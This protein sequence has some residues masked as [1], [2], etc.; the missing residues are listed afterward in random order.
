MIT[1]SIDD[2]KRDL[3]GYLRRVRAGE[4]LLITEADQPVAELKP[5]LNTTDRGVKQSR[6][7]ALC[8]GEFVVPDG[9]DDPLPEEI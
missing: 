1:I 5:I 8:E 3:I 7:F 4:T 2:M 9:F 6:P